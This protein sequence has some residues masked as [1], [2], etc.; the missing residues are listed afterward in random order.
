MG[1]GGGGGGVTLFSIIP[2][3]ACVPKTGRDITASIICSNFKFCWNA[4]IGL[5]PLLHY[6]IQQ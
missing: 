6:I 5:I 2:R 4:I 1:G 3:C